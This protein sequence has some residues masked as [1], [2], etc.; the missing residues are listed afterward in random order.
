MG[1]SDLVTADEFADNLAPT[2]IQGELL[3][4]RTGLSGA[5]SSDSPPSAAPE[6]ASPLASLPVLL[7]CKPQSLAADPRRLLHWLGVIEN[8]LLEACDAFDYGL[9][10]NAAHHVDLATQHARFRRLEV[11]SRELI[12]RSEY[13]VTQSIPRS[14]G[15]RGNTVDPRALAGFT[16]RQIKRFRERYCGL[17]REG[18]EKV[19]LAARN[20]GSPVTVGAIADQAKSDR[21]KEGIPLAEWFVR[22]FGRPL[23]SDPDVHDRLE[24]SDQGPLSL[25]VRAS[26]IKAA[27]TCGLCVDEWIVRTLDKQANA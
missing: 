12:V 23:P 14:R 5:S 4:P 10:R 15:G 11:L 26:W 20:T 16:P 1:D 6:D 19:L 9:C 2:P 21:R 17:S 8:A 7:E 18:L 13:E 27:R 3:S 24:D 25:P 22:N